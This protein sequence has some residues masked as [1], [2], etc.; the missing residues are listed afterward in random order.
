MTSGIPIV[1]AAE[2]VRTSRP[3]IHCITNIVTVNDCANVILAFGG[4]PVMAES[5]EEVAEFVAL[6]NG[7]NINLG[8]TGAQI[9]EADFIAGKRANELGVPVTFDP[10]GAGASRLR[11]DFSAQLLKDVR[12]SAIRGNM[13]EMKAL[14]TGVGDTK[15]VDVSSDDEITE[16]NWLEKG[17]ALKRFAASIG[18]VV[19]ASGPIDV[20]TDGRVVCGVHNGSPKMAQITGSGC[21]LTSVVRLWIAAAR[22]GGGRISD[23]EAVVSAIAT[24][25]ICGEIAE[26]KTQFKNGGLLTFRTE[27][28]DAASMITLEEI[29]KYAKI[30]VV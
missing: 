13:S 6:S 4:S 17:E 2:L 7:L 23:F 25:G 22:M 12:L 19:A 8:A 27:L 1:E 9:L 30:E 26:K 24:F 28:I 20:V 16:A 11:N 21:M 29:G 15:G 18:T 10:V 14:A 5:P 3:L